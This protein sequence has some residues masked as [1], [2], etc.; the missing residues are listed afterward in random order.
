MKTKFLIFTIHLFCVIGYSQQDTQ[1]TQYIYNTSAVNPAYAGTRGVTS[2]FGLHRAQWVGMDGAPVTNS[3]SINSPLS[4]RIGGGF[5]VLNDQIGPIGKSCVSADISYT[6]KISEDFNLSFGLKGSYNSFK[7]NHNKLNPKSPN[8]KVLGDSQ[9]YFSPNIGAGIYYYSE[10]LY[11]GASMPNFFQNYNYDD[12]SVTIN[13]DLMNFYVIGGYIIDLSTNL[14][15]KPAFITK[16]VSGSPFQLDISGNFLVNDKFVVGASWRWSAAAS[17]MVG[18]QISRGA[19]IGYGYDLE[20]TKL[21]T[22]N[23][24]SHELFFRFDLFKNN[25][26]I[27]SPRFF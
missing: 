6:V 16:V 18:F 15:F 11:L 23:S 12:A 25:D 13:K 4:S 10:K 22:Y 27:T 17:V 3:I 21:S 5:S 7:I 8:D 9:N 20:T 2:I 14:K 24:G 19:Y 1:Y 26:G